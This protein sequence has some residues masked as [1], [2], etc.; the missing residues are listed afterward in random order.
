M[1]FTPS[2][3]LKHV[4]KRTSD[5]SKNQDDTQTVVAKDYYKK[6]RVA[7]DVTAPNIVRKNKDITNNDFHFFFNQRSKILEGK[8]LEIP[9]TEPETIV[10]NHNADLSQNHPQRV[11]ERLLKQ[12]KSDYGIDEKEVVYGKQ[13]TVNFIFYVSIDGYLVGKEKTDGVNRIVIAEGSFDNYGYWNLT[14]IKEHYILHDQNN[15][16]E[17]INET[18]KYIY[19]NS[20]TGKLDK[21]THRFLI[22]KKRKEIDEI[23]NNTQ[24]INQDAFFGL[25]KYLD[26]QTESK[27]GLLDYFYNFVVPEGRSLGWPDKYIKNDYAPFYII[28]GLKEAYNPHDF[29]NFLWGNAIKKLNIDLEFALKR[30][31]KFAIKKH[32]EPDTK[33]DR[34]ANIQGYRY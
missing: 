3:P 6:I 2:L 29:G 11:L 17:Y 34:T 23:T 9:A 21:S 28:E 25:G 12:L 30:A 18:I 7:K 33:E 1:S 27:G 31:N 4:F 13:N 10:I 14:K 24:Q 16:N 32:G 8:G 15:D 19:K 22:Y 20:Y 26:V 5:V